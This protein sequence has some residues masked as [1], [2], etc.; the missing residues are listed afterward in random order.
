[1]ELGSDRILLKC[2]W[3]P[4][5]DDH[6]ERHHLIHF[7]CKHC[8][9]MKSACQYYGHFSDEQEVE[10]KSERLP[11]IYDKPVC[12]QP[13]CSDTDFMTATHNFYQVFQDKDGHCIYVFFDSIKEVESFFR[14]FPAGKCLEDDRTWCNFHAVIHHHK[15]LVSFGQ[16]KEMEITVRKKPILKNTSFRYQYVSGFLSNVL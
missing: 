5:V 7:R 1:M 13:Q 2:M 15:T 10:C 9:R 8:Q 6:E 14:L 3:I 16:F 11:T 12:N 4:P